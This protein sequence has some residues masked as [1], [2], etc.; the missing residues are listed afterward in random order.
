MP[1]ARFALPALAIL[2]TALRHW[3]V[4]RSDEYLSA[5]LMA[6]IEVLQSL[7]PAIVPRALIL[8]AG[9]PP[10]LGACPD[11][12]LAALDGL[13]ALPLVA[14]IEQPIIGDAF[15]TLAVFAAELPRA[16]DTLIDTISACIGE[17]LVTLF[18]SSSPRATRQRVA[19]PH[20][21]G[22]L[23]E[24][25]DFAFG[26]IQ[27]LFLSLIFQFWNPSGPHEIPVVLMECCLR[28]CVCLSLTRLCVFPLFDISS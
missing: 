4:V 20:V 23:A 13:L 16:A 25:D 12:V 26:E 22:A 7:D 8:A 21:I 2:P 10:L 15:G 6:L 5:I 19:I 9:W 3:I 28:H 27:G 17:R 18:A 14:L 24:R 1:P 11:P